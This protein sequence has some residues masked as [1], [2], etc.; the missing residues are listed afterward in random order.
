MDFF[1]ELFRTL[2]YQPFLNAL[3]LLYEYLPGRDFGVA[4]IALTILLRLV[5]YP[6]S[7]KAAIA[8]KKFAELQP[9]IKEIQEKFK[10]NKEQQAKAVFE[11]YRKEKINPFSPLLPLLIQFPILIALYQLFWKGF[12]PEQLVFLYSFVP[13]PGIINTSFLGFMD[14]AQKSLFFAVAAGILQFFQAKQTMPAK[15]DDSKK[16]GATDFASMLRTQ[17]LFVFPVVIVLIGA[18][19][20]AVISLYWAVS[21][22]F[23]IWQ[24]WFITRN[25]QHK[26]PKKV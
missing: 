2:L 6:L 15:K 13:T 25:Q 4:V 14:L 20:P 10:D 26:T 5:L 16:K 23:S 7:A 17:T 19:L 11:F 3:I 8:Q 22:A 9:R 24:Y 12:G 21:S 1:V 18:R